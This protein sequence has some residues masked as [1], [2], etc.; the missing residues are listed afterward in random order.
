MAE[1]SQRAELPLERLVAWLGI[2]RSKFYSWRERYG[3]VN[4]HNGRIPRDHWLLPE[5]D[6]AIL[7][8]QAEYPWE[9]YRRL[10]YMMLDRG[11]CACSPTSVY[12][13]LSEAGRLVKWNRRPS[14]KGTGFEQPLAPHQHWHID[15][16]VPQ[17]AA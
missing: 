3:K 2:T 14:K 9:G 13:V 1:L 4:E 8:F 11:V 12:R 10:T 16:S 6:K 5:E 15:I 7:D 17:K